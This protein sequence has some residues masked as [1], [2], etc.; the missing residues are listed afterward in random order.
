MYCSIDRHG[1]F[2][3]DHF[4]GGHPANDRQKPLA[5][6]FREMGLPLILQGV[7]GGK[8]GRSGAVCDA[9]GDHYWIRHLVK[10]N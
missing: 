10:A 1:V 2:N 9:F 3:C 4:A 8:R 6:R 5:F 7:D